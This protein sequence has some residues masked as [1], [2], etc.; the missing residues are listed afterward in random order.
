MGHLQELRLNFKVIYL[1]GIIRAR[2]PSIVET[3]D[4]QLKRLGHPATEAP[5]IVET[6]DEKQKKAGH[7]PVGSLDYSLGTALH[8]EVKALNSGECR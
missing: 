2:P 4:T 1:S 8:D 5:S 6:T 7:P 3:T